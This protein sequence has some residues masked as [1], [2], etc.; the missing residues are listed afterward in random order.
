MYHYKEHKIIYFYPQLVFSYQKL[1]EI[2][3]LKL[4]EKKL[5]SPNRSS[6][7]VMTN[8]Q[9]KF[10]YKSQWRKKKKITYIY[11]YKMTNRSLKMCTL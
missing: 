9:I 7:S 6:H 5:T 10:N 11:I 3:L 4:K 8:I 1:L 2:Q